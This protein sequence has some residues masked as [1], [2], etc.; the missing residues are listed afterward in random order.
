MKK[1][2]IVGLVLGCLGLVTMAAADTV[3]G[4]DVG[5][6][7]KSYEEPGVALLRGFAFDFNNED[8]HIADVCIDPDWPPYPTDYPRIMIT[9]A[10]KNADDGF[11]YFVEHRRT[12]ANGVVEATCNFSNCVGTCSC[13]L[14]AP[15][16]PSYVFALRG[17]RTVF[18]GAGNDHELKGIG[19][20]RDGNVA[21]IGYRDGNGDDKFQGFVE[22]AWL[23]PGLVEATGRKFLAGVGDADE[24][25][26]PAA[27]RTVIGGFSINYSDGDRYVDELGV[28]INDT[29]VLMEL[30]DK[31]DD[32]QFNGFVDW[33]R[34]Y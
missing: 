28:W 8:H 33:V 21:R 24:V 19:V 32:D 7:V 5:T 16:A 13:T 10:D 27:N 20:W 34:L 4:N 30:N 31:N 22:Y 1:I 26:L 14:V 17:F 2:V 12:T 25:S 23:S 18:T 11:S 29:S 6:V 15:P 9:Y 3:S